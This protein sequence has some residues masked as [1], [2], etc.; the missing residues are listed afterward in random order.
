MDLRRIFQVQAKFNVEPGNSGIFQP[1]GFV[2]ATLRLPRLL[3]GRPET[4]LPQP[5][6]A[7][8]HYYE[9]PGEG[10][11]PEFVAQA[12][13]ISSNMVIDLIMAPEDGKDPQIE[14]GF[15]TFTVMS[16]TWKPQK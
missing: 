12:G 10:G 14:A 3:H 1:L 9:L 2:Q 13:N 11:S 7:A 4:V 6:Q 8:L 15:I 5:A 16:S